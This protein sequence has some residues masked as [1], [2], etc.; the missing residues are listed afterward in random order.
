MNGSPGSALRWI[1]DELDR[2][3]IPFQAVGG[4]AARAHGGTRP[5]VDLDFYIPERHLESV[6]RALAAHVVRPLAE[7]RDEHWDLTFLVLD[8]AGWRIEIA[9]AESARV[10]DVGSGA[11]M[12]ADIG[13][14]RSVPIEVDGVSIPVMPRSELLAYKRGLDR[15]VDRADLAELAPPASGDHPQDWNGGY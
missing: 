15:E 13:F 10:R 8:W 12:P 5:L 14:D 7:H 2:M 1:R 6:A 3:G 4:L 9:G 11:W